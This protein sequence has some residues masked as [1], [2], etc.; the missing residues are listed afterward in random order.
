MQHFEFGFHRNGRLVGIVPLP[1]E[2]MAIRCFRGERSVRP[3]LVVT[4]IIRLQ[5]RDEGE[6]E[7]EGEVEGKDF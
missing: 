1:L 5:W 4:Q 7:G 6:G 3:E 2:V